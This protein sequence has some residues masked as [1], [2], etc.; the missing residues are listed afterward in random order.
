MKKFNCTSATAWWG[1]RPTGSRKYFGGT[2]QEKG[3]L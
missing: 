3:V 1:D 2:K